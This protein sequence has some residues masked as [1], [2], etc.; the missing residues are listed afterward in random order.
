MHSLLQA[1]P[2][3]ELLDDG[4]FSAST[5]A[6]TLPISFVIGPAWEAALRK[7]AADH[8]VRQLRHYLD[9]SHVFLTYFSAPCHATRFAERRL[10]SGLAHGGTLTSS[11]QDGCDLTLGSPHTG[12]V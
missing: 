1:A 10:L 9:H 11:P 4:K 7:S 5:L 8:G 6:D 12:A 2:W 3:H